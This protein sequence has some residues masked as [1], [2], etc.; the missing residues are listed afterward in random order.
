MKSKKFADIS[1]CF[2]RISMMSLLPRDS[3]GV[4]SG[5]TTVMCWN[6]FSQILPRQNTCNFLFDRIKSLISQSY[7]HAFE[8]MLNWRNSRYF[9]QMVHSNDTKY[10]NS[11][12]KMIRWK[13]QYFACLKFTVASEKLWRTRTLNFSFSLLSSRQLNKSSRLLLSF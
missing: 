5:N 9:S 1:F 2:Q 11:T 3:L 6:D 10:T 8:L 7:P 12:W 4:P 13:N